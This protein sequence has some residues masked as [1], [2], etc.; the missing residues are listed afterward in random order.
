[1]STLLITIVPSLIILGFFTLSDKFKEPKG[2]ILL[3]FFLGFLICL[4][5]GILNSF[6]YDQFNTGTD[7]S[8]KLYS[9]FLAPAWT[10]EILKFII[11]YTIVLRRHEFNEP[12]DGIVYG[13]TVSLGFAT[14]EN[15]IF[16]LVFP[17][18]IHGFYN[19]VDYPFH[20]F[21]VVGLLIYALILHSNLKMIQSEKRKEKEIKKI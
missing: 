8:E 1:V 6:M 18:L 9:S 15:L 4:P 20:Y 19:F 7:L 3:I 12:M 13:V 2:T 16:A 10:E 5:A 14:Y 11:L 17:Y 21:I